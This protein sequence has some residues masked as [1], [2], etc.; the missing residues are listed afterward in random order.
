MAIYDK[1]YHIF[2]HRGK[3]LLNLMS[4]TPPTPLPPGTFYIIDDDSEYI[5]DDDGNKFTSD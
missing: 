1:R 5:L 3:I 4:G 2:P